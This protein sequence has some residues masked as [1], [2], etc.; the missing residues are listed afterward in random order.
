MV[1]IVEQKK[2]SVLGSAYGLED[3]KRTVT[4]MV[5]PDVG[6]RWYED[7]ETLYSLDRLG[8][9]MGVILLEGSWS[10]LDGG[11]ELSTHT[12]LEDALRAG[13]RHAVR[14]IHGPEEPTDNRRRK[15]VWTLP[16]AK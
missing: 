10:V 13:T 6:L 16:Q 7:T 2:Q 14:E 4:V 8:I 15:L 11:Y 3:S 5:S 12:T 9:S 1:Q